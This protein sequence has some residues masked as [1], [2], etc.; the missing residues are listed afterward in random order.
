GWAASVS[1]MGNRHLVIAL[2]VTPLLAMTGWWASGLFSRQEPAP[3]QKGGVYPLLERSNCR[4]ASGQCL[5]EN[6]DFTIALT[7][8]LGS[9]GHFLLARAS[10]PL[11]DILLAVGEDEQSAPQSMERRGMNSRE[12]RLALDDRPGAAA[13][14]RL[15]A[16]SADVI[17]YG[18]AATHFIKAPVPGV[19]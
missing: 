12:W 17:W 14:I 2:M 18:D 13:R 16:R 3:A 15:V 8:V 4:Y 6:V 5:L 19:Q 10:H 11:S 1:L 7:Y 9:D